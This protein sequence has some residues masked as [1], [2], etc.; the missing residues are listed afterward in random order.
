MQETQETGWMPELGRS[1]G[2]GNDNS[3]QYSSLESPVDRKA[4][5]ASPQGGK[6]SDTAEAT[7]HTATYTVIVNETEL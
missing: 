5:R 4:W 1:P 3:L 7:D 6:E 2:G